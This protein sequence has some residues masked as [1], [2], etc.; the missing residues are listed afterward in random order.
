MLLILE[1]RDVQSDH[2]II[3]DA[4][5]SCG[6][7]PCHHDCAFVVR[8]EDTIANVFEYLAVLASVAIPCAGAPIARVRHRCR[9]DRF[10][11]RVARS[12]LSVISG[13]SR[14]WEFRCLRKHL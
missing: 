10:R 8:D 7:P 5:Q 3:P 2:F 6:D 12:E 14:K 1:F 11:G 9:T 4:D 13:E